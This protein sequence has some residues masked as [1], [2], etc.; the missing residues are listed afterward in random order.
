MS[1]FRGGFILC[2]IA[3]PFYFL[4]AL[5]QRLRV[6]FRELSRFFGAGPAGNVQQPEGRDRKGT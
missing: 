2:C 4:V 3:C 5:L 6:D 1:V